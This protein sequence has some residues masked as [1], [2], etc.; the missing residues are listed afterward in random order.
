MNIGIDV[1]TLFNKITGQGVYLKN[2]ILSL[3]YIDKVNN[4]FLYCNKDPNLD[5]NDNFKIIQINDNL[6]IRSKFEYIFYNIKNKIDVFI[7]TKSSD[8]L[9][10]HPRTITIIYDAGP[11]IL[12]KYY[13]VKQI[14]KF[15]TLFK[16][17]LRRSKKIITLSSI[18]KSFIL[19]KY[20]INSNKIIKIPASVSRWT[21]N[22]V[23]NEDIKRV[24][25]KYNLPE[26]YFLFVGTLER[27]KNI[28][29]LVKAFY[30]FKKNDIYK[31]KLIIVGKIAYECKKVFK[32]IINKRLSH[33]VIFTGHIEEYDLKPIY[34]LSKAFVLPSFF[35]GSNIS[36]LEAFAC[37]IPVIC[38]KKSTLGEMLKN[39]YL[40]VD[41]KN[42]NTIKNAL[43]E[44][45]T[46][47]YLSNIL[48]KNSNE[49]KE[50]NKWN[51]STKKLLKVINSI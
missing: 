15:K 9:F 32:C 26:N 47:K 50:K 46:D 18:V 8:L 7:I 43:Y 13:N 41:P 37:K 29:N 11:I 10:F 27:R 44:I 48:V 49:I 45:S 25:I 36:I 16:L 2:I 12:S 5:L 35:E 4:Y 34:V 3:N 31:F 51:K 6:S 14:K 19:N 40:E 33:D 20:K 17:A 42:I 39:S 22:E 24:V 30:E 23:K 21:E 28:L 38:S 1:N